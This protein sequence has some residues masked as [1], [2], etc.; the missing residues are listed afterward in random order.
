MDSEEPPPEPD[1][2]RESVIGYAVGGATHRAFHEITE[3]S[4]R[5]RSRCP[6]CVAFVCKVLDG[7]AEREVLLEDA[8]VLVHRPAAVALDIAKRAGDR[9]KQI[10]GDEPLAEAGRATDRA[11]FQLLTA[12]RW[13][14]HGRSFYKAAEARAASLG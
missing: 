5:S 8:R 13:R 14:D 2:G 3:A 4:R 6:T 12:G 7:I 11:N 1:Q 10:K 9:V